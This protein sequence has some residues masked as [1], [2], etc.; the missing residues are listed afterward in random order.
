MKLK[1]LVL[2]GAI[3]AMGFSVKKAYADDMTIGRPSF[4]LGIARSDYSISHSSVSISTHRSRSRVIL[5]TFRRRPST[6][7]PDAFFA[8]TPP[9]VTDRLPTQQ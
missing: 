8:I 2:M 7:S 5:L 1:A 4:D 6:L 3:L 9:Q